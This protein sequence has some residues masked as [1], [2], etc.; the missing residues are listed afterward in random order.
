MGY[1]IMTPF[2]NEKNKNEM[3]EFLRNNYRN[4]WQVLELEDETEISAPTD[5]F[6]YIHEKG[7]YVGFN[8]HRTTIEREYAFLLCKWMAK[9]NGKLMKTNTYQKIPYILYDGVARIGLVEEKIKNE[10]EKIKIE[11]VGRDGYSPLPEKMSFLYD[12]YGTSYKEGERKIQHEL[13]RLTKLW[14]ERA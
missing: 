7:N 10:E 8:Y 13:I 6:P 4:A 11:E 2:S 3:L 9:M 12:D 14:K 1:S 5:N